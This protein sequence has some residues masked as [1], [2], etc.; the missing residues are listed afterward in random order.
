M[1]YVIDTNV[2]LLAVDSTGCPVPPPV[3]NVPTWWEGATAEQVRSQMQ[4]ASIDHALVVATGSYDD[5]YCVASAERYP[6][7]FTAI[8]KLD[9]SAANAVE[10]L[11][12]MVAQSGVGGVRFEHRGEGANPSAWLDDPRLRPLWETALRLEIRVSLGA[13]RKMEHLAA[14]RRVLERFPSLT[15]ILRRMVQPPLADGP[16]YLGAAPLFALAAYPNVYSTF[17]HLNIEEAD[18]GD[19]TH[20]AFFEAFLARFGARRLMW[21]SFFPA[22]RSMPDGSI[23]GLLEY[24]RTQL[25][26][27]PPQDIDL[28]LGETARGLYSS[29]R[30]A[31]A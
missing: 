22:Y 28:L 18:Q 6:S 5:E 11:E 20:R 13:V 8:G 29:M 21:A 31:P 14:L 16:P 10:A 23:N 2:H 26:F 9:V 7:S 1:P 19:S 24:V 30:V 3:G 4:Q 25:A 27:L 17:S 12:R 15:V